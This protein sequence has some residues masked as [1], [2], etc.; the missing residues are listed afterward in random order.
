MKKTAV[1]TLIA[2]ILLCFIIVPAMA[3]GEIEILNVSSGMPGNIFFDGSDKS[4]SVSFKNNT[5]SDVNAHIVY[6]VTDISEKNTDTVYMQK[7]KEVTIGALSEYT[8]TVSAADVAKY[9]VYE[10]NIRITSDDGSIEADKTVPFSVCVDASQNGGNPKLASCFHVSW[11]ADRL[12]YTAVP[13]LKKAGFSSV[14][15]SYRW[16]EFEKQKGSFTEPQRYTA[17]YDAIDNNLSKAFVICSLGNKLHGMQTDSHMPSTNEQRAAFAEYVYQ[18]LLINK[19]SIEA[20]EV[21]NEPDLENFN[22]GSVSPADYAKLVKAVY[23]KV[24]SNSEFANIKIAAP[25]L[26]SYTSW[27]YEFLNADLDGDGKCDTYKY[28]DIISIHQ[29]ESVYTRAVTRFANIKAELG[30]YNAADKEI[31]YTEFGSHQA[32]NNGADD[33]SGFSSQEMQ[34]SRLVRYYLTISANDSGSKYYMYAFAEEPLAVS[35]SERTFGITRAHNYDVPYA[36][37]A[38]LIAVANM[39]SLLHE[40]YSEFCTEYSEDENGVCI[41]SFKNAENTREVKA[42][43]RNFKQGEETEDSITYRLAAEPQAK[44]VT[45]YDLYGN[46]IHFDVSDGYYS[47]DVSH[48]TVY[49][50]FDYGENIHMY[51]DGEKTVVYGNLTGSVAGEFI[52]LKVLS[53]NGKIVYI[54]QKQLGNEKNF[55]F[56]FKTPDRDKQYILYLGNKS[57]SGI[58][59]VSFKPYVLMKASVIATNENSTEISEL[60]DFISAESVVIKSELINPNVTDFKILAAY[61]KNNAVTKVDV[62][63]KNDMTFNLGL[64]EYNLKAE[65]IKAEF[66]TV[67]VFMLDSLS[68]ITPLGKNL[69]IE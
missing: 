66:D 48:K 42:L 29:Y 10:L 11:S 31:Y 44:T 37:K 55:E 4:F 46:K 20:I 39:N 32:Y 53:E 47:I 22:P 26:A 49:A 3:S 43:F 15:D 68:D 51:P 60:L 57:F 59:A 16:A 23:E 64:Y 50:V 21:W 54:E 19:D 69:V 1:L 2:S 67:K 40:D 30:K 9:N 6:T 25:A 45:F 14:R 41:A 34:A 8:D 24:R 58:Y 17:L 35:D 18:M 13:I 5:G 62:I 12:P 7:N 61:Y 33:E 36:A 56:S 63:N 52:T 28:F 65:P 27:L 38:A